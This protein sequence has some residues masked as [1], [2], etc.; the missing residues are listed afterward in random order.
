M[1]E[2]GSD[3]EVHNVYL[4]ILFLFTYALAIFQAVMNDI[5][6]RLLRKCVLELF[7]VFKYTTLIGKLI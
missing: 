7:M 3:H 1:K 6:K 2:E 5:L 4:E